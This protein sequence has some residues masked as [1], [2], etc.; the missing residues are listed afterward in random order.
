MTAPTP[1]TA[2]LALGLGFYL[3]DTPPVAGVLKSDAEDFEVVEISAHPLPD[4]EGAFTI[5]RVRSRDWEQHE[6]AQAIASRLGLAP[7]ALAWAGTKD[8]RAV[9]ERLFSYR[10]PTPSASIDLPNASIL[11]AYRARDGLSLGHLFGNSFDLRVTGLTGPAA[12]AVRSF[13]QTRDELRRFGGFP[14]F[15]GPQRFGEVRPVT[16]LVGRSIVQGRPEEAVERYLSW[17]P[18][19]GDALGA[20]ARRSYAQHHDPARAL[21][22]FPPTFRFE[23]RLLDHLARG[24]PPARALRA[25]SHELRT[26]FVHAYQALLFNRWISGR[27]SSGLSLFVPVPG[28][29]ILRIAP[30]G[31]IS[32]AMAA[33]VEEDNRRECAELVERGRAVVAGPLVGYETPPIDGPSGELLEELLTIEGTTRDQFRSPGAPD[34]ASRGGWRPV[35][36]PTPPIAI[37]ESP[38]RNPDANPS[39]GV[40]MRF[41]LPKGSYATV[42]LREFLKTGASASSATLSKRL[43]K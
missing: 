2:D 42:L 26:L 32:G 8:R 37:S 34:L 10:G 43:F 11:E 24:H 30:D 14:N 28:D 22:E 4:P 19:E 25:L 1:P 35:Y 27:A 9:S 23:R 21:A 7:H 41:S 36:V 38:A 40:R 16:H 39:D 17:L 20:E 5:L 15:F 29:R 13:T 31:T 33:Q 3:T 6:L 18:D 12:D